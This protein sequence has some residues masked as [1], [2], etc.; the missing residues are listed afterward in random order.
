[1]AISITSCFASKKSSFAYFL[2][3]LRQLPGKG[4]AGRERACVEKKNG[5][6]GKENPT[7]QRQYGLPF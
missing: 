6:A 7:L 3:S 5:A 1:V 4:P 2:L